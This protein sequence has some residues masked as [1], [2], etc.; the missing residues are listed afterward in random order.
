MLPLLVQLHAVLTTDTALIYIIPSDNIGASIRQNAG[1]PVLEYEIGGEEADH[2]GHRTI[3]LVFITSSQTGAEE[4]YKIKEALE[5]LV[6]AKKLSTPETGTLDFS[7]MQ[8][9][10]TDSVFQSR[11]GW[12]H[13]LRTEF[14]LR[15]ADK[16][17]AT[18]KQ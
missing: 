5:Q 6:T 2:S 10:L 1:S 18:Q 16:R 9:R 12:A 15:V 11:S 3:V 17:P 14:T 7:V 13:T 4:C 8:A